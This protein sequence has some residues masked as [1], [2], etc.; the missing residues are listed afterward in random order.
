MGIAHRLVED[1]VM[2]NHPTPVAT[3]TRAER[4][5]A[6]MAEIRPRLEA[7]ARALAERAV[8]VAEAE[9]FGAIDTEFRDAGLKIANEIRQAGLAG[10]KKRATSGAA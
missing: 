3:P 5:E 9:E 1:R 2:A 6:I 4:V 7:T 8:D 10:R